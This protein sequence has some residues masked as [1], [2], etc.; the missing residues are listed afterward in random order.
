MASENGI[1][2]SHYQGQI[3]WPAAKASGI[4][5]AIGKVTQGVASIDDRWLANR[6]AARA[7]GVKVAG[8]HFGD[9]NQDPK[10]SADT[11]RLTLGTVDFTHAWLDFEKNPS[12]ALSR[13]A[14]HDWVHAW[15]AEYGAPAGVY[16][17]DYFWDAM[18]DA[19]G[20]AECAARPLWLARYASSMGEIPHPWTSAAIWQHSDKGQVPGIGGSVDL[21]VFVSESLADLV[22]GATTGG[23]ELTDEEKQGLLA[24][25]EHLIESHNGS[26]KSDLHGRID[27]LKKDVDKQIN[28]LY[29]SLARA[30]FGGKISTGHLPMSIQGAR[31]DIITEIRKLE[32]LVK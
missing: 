14:M 8:Y 27:D 18:V 10:R 19:A 7:A 24:S 1:D 30:E 23:N 22:A 28:Q 15:F 32:E 12:P 21:D 3:D 16:T 9:P 31:N 4:Q 6:D 2:F 11:F 29:T 20:C 5:F 26:L 17:A 13:Q 25:I